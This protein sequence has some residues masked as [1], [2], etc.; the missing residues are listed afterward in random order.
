MNKY[1]FDKSVSPFGCLRI[2][3][4]YGYSIFK[5]TRSDLLQKYKKIL[6][7]EN[8]ELIIN[9]IYHI[10]VQPKRSG[11][12]A[13]KALSLPNGWSRYPIIHRVRDLS[14]GKYKLIN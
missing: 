7:E 5:T 6:G 14:P 8:S 3:G 9:Y 13:F 10:N 12:I 4:P 1:I 11:E 2:L